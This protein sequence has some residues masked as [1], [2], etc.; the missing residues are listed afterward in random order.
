VA[1]LVV[2]VTGLSLQ[3]IDTLRN[4]P[5]QV[6]T[7]IQTAERSID[8]IKNGEDVG[9]PLGALFG[10]LTEIADSAE[11]LPGIQPLLQQVRELLEALPVGD[12]AD[13]TEIVNA[14][15]EVLALFGPVKDSI[16]SGNLDTAV[17]QAVSRVE[18]FVQSLRAGGGD[19]ISRLTGE[20]SEFFR[21][22]GQLVNWRNSPP[23]SEDVAQL[24]CKIL[25][26]I[27]LDLLA[28]A[29]RA[30]DEALAPLADLLPDDPKLE[31]WRGAGPRLLGFWQDIDAR[32][33]GAGA[34]DW[35]ALGIEL[36]A[37]RAALLELTATRDGLA[38]AV[39]RNLGSVRVN[40]FSGVTTALAN[41]PE[42][43]VQKLG[44]ILDGL[45]FQLRGMVDDLTAWTPTE[46][47]LRATVRQFVEGVLGY[48]D[49]TP[50]GELRIMM[51]NFQQ[52]LLQAVE[53]LPFRDLARR[54]EAALRQVA[55]AVDVIDPEAVRQPI[56]DYFD[57][58]RQRIEELPTEDI[59]NAT[60]QL[61]SGV[62]DVLNQVRDLVEQFRTTIEGA[63]GS[64]ETFLEGVRPT[65]QQI[66][67]QVA[68]IK[69]QLEEFDLN[70][71]AD[72]VIGELNKL[73]DKVAELDLSEVPEAARG[74]IN[75]AVDLLSGIDI[76]VS[77]KG[78]VDEALAKVDPTPLL[79]Q[80][81]SS[82]SGATDV[83]QSLN[84]AHVLVELDRPVDDIV[85]AIQEFGPEQFRKL[86]Q[87]ALDPVKDAVRSIEF[88]TL[89]A[90]LTKLYAEMTARVDGVLNPDVVFG[91][92]EALF[93]PIID[94]LDAIHPKKLVDLL[95]P[96]LGG[97]T[98]G[99]GAAAGPPESVTSGGQALRESI[100][101]S[102]GDVEDP[103]FGFR[104]GD[105]LVPLVDLHRKLIE[106]VDSLSE[107][108]LGPAAERLQRATRGRFD[109]LEPRS[110]AARVSA[111]TGAVQVEFDPAAL[112]QRLDAAN[113]QFRSVARRLGE[114]ARN[115]APAEQAAAAA[116]LTVLHELDPM[117]LMPDLAQVDGVRSASL[118][119]EAGIDLREMR[120]GHAALAPR[121]TQV[122][123]S[124]LERT[125]LGAGLLRGALAALDPAPIREEI[126][127]LFEQVGQRLVGLQGALLGAFEELAV[128]VERYFLPISPA[129]LVNLATTLHGTAKE[130]IVALGPATFKDE[131]KL[132]FDVVKR[133]LSVLDPAFLA[134]EFNLVREE[135]LGKLD[136]LVGALVPSSAAFDDVVL[137]IAELK[138]SRL[139]AGVAEQ[140]EPLT[141]LIL[142]LDPTQLLAP[143]I[144]A[145][146]NVRAE[147]PDVLARLEAAL[148]D[149]LQALK[150]DAGGSV[151]GEVSV[152]A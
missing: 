117:R 67:D 60:G 36:H 39:V 64:V 96:H 40:G 6:E 46:E 127:T 118:S 17:T 11:G 119:F 146:A 138:P 1:D 19:D 123:P 102:V 76:T 132:I 50:L 151:Q 26:G 62:E 54:A 14:V 5:Q 113:G 84:P 45:R 77:V 73:R 38:A 79:E 126:N 34:I 101:S 87:Q 122:L 24:L 32:F 115:A 16:V 130:Q 141:E 23:S 149:V 116:V 85:L 106:M 88:E 107:E 21:L 128:A 69:A 70:Q 135:L 47:E 7:L 134:E 72:V 61:W 124:F 140:L 86:L 150:R 28:D 105:L 90:P 136:E 143:I 43:A 59:K 111:S 75:V 91:P 137:R 13:V 89:M 10:S 108:T 78:P 129:S 29:E 142:Q 63:A 65:L 3:E 35:N 66:T 2:R 121:L 125:D 95:T 56:R 92:L 120:T 104:P 41:M 112:S 139:L 83:L 82:L 48:L 148:D 103:L 31:A 20:L 49:R 37:G 8:A 53:S 9:N 42:I 44:S 4:L 30:L 94:L 33:L 68:E 147:V 131:V 18:D 114:A 110:V 25:V 80:A 145:I 74:A 52:T 22:F 55:D 81:M 58:I 152:A 51:I 15:E 144:D 100:T 133:Q 99:L 93:Q 109:A 98:A 27:P 97:A 71:P 12:L 57:A